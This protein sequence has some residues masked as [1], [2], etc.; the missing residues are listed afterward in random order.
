MEARKNRFLIFLRT[1]FLCKKSSFF[2]YIGTLEKTLKKNSGW[3]P[4]PGMPV[5][6][7]HHYGTQN[8]KRDPRPSADTATIPYHHH[9]VALCSAL[10][11]KK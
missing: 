7:S 4:D 10:P 5:V 8:I 1:I 2:S 3:V 11:W 9:L 6:V